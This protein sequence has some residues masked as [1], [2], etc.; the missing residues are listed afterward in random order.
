MDETTASHHLVNILPKDA[1]P[2]ASS[3]DAVEASQKEEQAAP[4]EFGC[5]CKVY[6]VILVLVALPFIPVALLIWCLYALLSKLTGSKGGSSPK[7]VAENESSHKAVESLHE[8]TPG[9]VA[10]PVFCSGRC[11]FIL[12]VAAVLLFLVALIIWCPF[13][14]LSKLL[15]IEGVSSPGKVAEI[16]NPNHNDNENDFKKQL[17]KIDGLVNEGVA[18]ARWRLRIL[19]LLLLSLVIV[20]F[21]PGLKRIK[22]LGLPL[23]IWMEMPALL[24]VVYHLIS[25]LGKIIAKKWEEKAVVYYL[26]GLRRSGYWFIV[27][28]VILLAWE[29][30]FRSP[31]HGLRRYGV[32]KKVLHIGTSL[33]ISLLVGAI[34]ALIKNWLILLW[35]SH[36][37]FRR[38]T[39]TKISEVGEQLYFLGLVYG[40][41]FHLFSPGK[42]IPHQAAK[43]GISDQAAKINHS[44]PDKRI[45]NQA[46]NMNNSSLNEG[47][48]HEAA[49]MKNS[50]NNKKE[51]SNYVKKKKAEYFI[52]MTTMFS[53]EDITNGHIRHEI[54]EDWEKFQICSS[55]NNNKY[56]TKESMKKNGQ[57]IK[58]SD[59][60]IKAFFEKLRVEDKSKDDEPNNTN[61]P[62]GQDSATTDEIPYQIFKDWMKKAFKNCLSFGYTLIDAQRA[63]NKLDNIIRVFIVIVAILCFLFLAGIAS[64]KVLVTIWTSFAAAAFIFGDML[65]AFFEGIIFVFV[66][67]PFNIGDLC[68]IDDTQLEVNSIDVLKTTFHRIDNKEE[69][70]YPNKLIDIDLFMCLRFFKKHSDEFEKHRVL[71]KEIGEFIKIA[72]EFKHKIQDDTHARYSKM[73]KKQRSKLL[74][75]VL[76]HIETKESSSTNNT[77]ESSGQKTCKT[78][79][80]ST[81]NTTESSRQNL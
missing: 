68:I 15:S 10:S 77:I 16:L 34:L 7:T 43:K 26:D 49:D 3:H 65:K 30:Y 38:C 69:V 80:S 53:R 11:L 62:K 14:L 72:I 73:K 28:V 9:P 59:N 63:K 40:F 31:R 23:L 32:S 79:S 37:I 19:L 24:I 41:R 55:D 5:W 58:F 70:L 76:N 56:I 66:M 57:A 12:Y 13:W 74:N 50:N 75:E 29:L 47:N 25:S 51:S 67:H 8:T 1:S 20:V 46:A 78:A 39:T 33:A 21:V 81:K 18:A 22:V 4:P 45:S 60:D 27:C 17:G 35:E 61:K 64:T 42:R 44:S 48:S 71:T 2:A 52:E 36:S 54:I 6:L